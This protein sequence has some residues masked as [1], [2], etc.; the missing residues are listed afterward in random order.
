[1][2]GFIWGNKWTVPFPHISFIWINLLIFV[3]KK[4]NQRDYPT[5]L[6]HIWRRR[7]SSLESHCFQCIGLKFYG[8]M[9][10]FN[11][12]NQKLHIP[13]RGLRVFQ[14]FYLWPKLKG[15]KKEPS[16][17]EGH[18]GRKGKKIYLM[19]NPPANILGSITVT[20][21]EWLH[22]VRPIGISPGMAW[23]ASVKFIG[24]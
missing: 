14:Y 13:S 9:P 4:T 3:I 7:K 16:I 19:T 1:M 2:R 22:G 23:Q 15:K 12:I 18:I 6:L 11:N 5:A 24:R 17:W 21:M 20:Q 10:I 8:A